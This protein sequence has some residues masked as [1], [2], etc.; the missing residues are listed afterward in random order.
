MIQKRL[1][2]YLKDLNCSKE[3]NINLWHHRPK[4]KKF[5]ESK[6]ITPD[7]PHIFTHPEV[8]FLYQKEIENLIN[9]KTGFKNFEKISKFTFLEKPFEVGKELSP[10]QGIIRYKINEIYQDKIKEMFV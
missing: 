3:L 2:N 9:A 7:F 1:Y 8:R 6:G 10:K 5:A 4:I